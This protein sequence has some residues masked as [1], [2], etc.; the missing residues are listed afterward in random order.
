MVPILVPVYHP[1]ELQIISYALLL[2]HYNRLS[3]TITHTS[4]S[5]GISILSSRKRW[6]I[7]VC[8]WFAYSVYRLLF[9]ILVFIYKTKFN[10]FD[11]LAILFLPSWYIL[12]QLQI[13]YCDIKY[14]IGKIYIFYYIVTIMINSKKCRRDMIFKI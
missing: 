14:V 9:K 6:T 12:P 11:Y 13:L 3:T 7:I 2:I 5:G 8:T 4:Y 10:F 1:D